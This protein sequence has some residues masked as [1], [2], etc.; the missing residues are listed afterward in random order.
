LW[1]PA[2]IVASLAVTKKQ[3]APIVQLIKDQHNSNEPKD[4]DEAS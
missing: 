1:I 3:A 4:V 2:L